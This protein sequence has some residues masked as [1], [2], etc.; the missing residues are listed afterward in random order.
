MNRHQIIL[1]G[2][3]QRKKI[4]IIIITPFNSEVPSLATGLVLSGWPEV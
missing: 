1:H 4:L 3:I 2:G